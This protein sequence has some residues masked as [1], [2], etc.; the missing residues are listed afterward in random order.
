MAKDNGLLEK[1][2]V[3]T[4][5]VG[6]ILFPAVL[7]AKTPEKVPAQVQNTCYVEKVDA[8]GNQLKIHGKLDAGEANYTESV[9]NDLRY[10]YNYI[11]SMNKTGIDTSY[12]IA[13]FIANGNIMK[14]NDGSY[15]FNYCNGKKPKT[16]VA[17]PAPPKRGK[18]T[19]HGGTIPGPKPP[20][21]VV[22]DTQYVKKPVYVDKP[23]TTWLP[24]S[25][26]VPVPVPDSQKIKWPV[27][28][29]VQDTIHIQYPPSEEGLFRLNDIKGD[30][31]HFGGFYRNENENMVAGNIGFDLR[32]IGENVRGNFAVDAYGLILPN[33]GH[34][35]ARGIIDCNAGVYNRN[36]GG[37][38][39]ALIDSSGV[40]QVGPYVNGAMSLG[41]YGP[42]I[43]GKLGV[44]FNTNDETFRHYVEA[45]LN[46]QTRS[47]NFALELKGRSGNDILRMAHTNS[48]EMNLGFGNKARLLLGFGGANGVGAKDIG[49]QTFKSFLQGTE[50]KYNIGGEWELNP[51]TKL[52]LKGTSKGKW[53]SDNK[54]STTQ[55]GLEAGARL[56]FD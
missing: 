27:P 29:I 1:I 32:T 17:T 45:A 19:G 13:N 5:V 40:G 2:S 31:I 43:S 15:W 23:D 47:K 53:D 48:A 12:S 56:A 44:D 3:G 35:G 36:I 30:N 28:V 42:V 16:P 33:R 22:P 20:V 34:N 54:Y 49:D 38:L 41:N 52:Y 7:A 9:K 24:V 39:H 11:Y 8:Q 37:G 4:F 6:S 46:Y 50:L 26:P 55:G 21:V 14:R 51:S 18:R 10:L 25:I